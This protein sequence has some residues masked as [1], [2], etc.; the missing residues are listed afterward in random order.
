MWAE[1]IPKFPA[2]YSNLLQIFNST[3][4]WN[5]AFFSLSLMQQ[6]QKQICNLK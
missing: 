5:V 6:N 4:F 3:I 2:Q 1:Q